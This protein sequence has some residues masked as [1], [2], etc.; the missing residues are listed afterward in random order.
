MSKHSSLL[1][2]NYASTMLTPY[3]IAELNF[4]VKEHRCLD[5]GIQGR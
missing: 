2:M 1:N 4:L 3:Q 5:S